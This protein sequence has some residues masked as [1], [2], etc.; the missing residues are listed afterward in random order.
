LTTPSLWSGFFS[1]TGDGKQIA[2]LALNPMTSIDKYAFDPVSGKV[3][4]TPTALLGGS[5]SLIEPDISPDGQWIALRSTGAQDDLYLLKSDGSGLRQLTSDAWRERTPMW[6]PDG[7]R[8]AFHS[9]RSGRYEAWT[10][11]PDG[12]GLTQLTHSKGYEVLQPRW[13]P[14][15]ARI[16]WEDGDRAGVID[17]SGAGGETNEEL[18]NVSE[19]LR[20]F[21]RTW[22]RDARSIYGSVSGPGSTDGGLWVY[23][24]DSHRYEKLTDIGD[25]PKLLRDGQRL[26]Y[27]RDAELSLFDLRS[28]QSSPVG[29]GRMYRGLSGQNSFAISPDNRWLCV[30]R[31]VSEGD[32]WVAN[33]EPTNATK[34]TA[35]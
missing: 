31:D 10:I 19:T 12:S 34:G 35:K 18:P 13:S 15:G 32:I 8:I 16:A 30:I 29:S 26:L 17:L 27:D 25:D 2:Y 7:K 23:S 28:R 1:I 3:L 33:L 20:F 4:G 22:T 5:L 9:D 6:S 24:L 11:Q 14:D 21:P